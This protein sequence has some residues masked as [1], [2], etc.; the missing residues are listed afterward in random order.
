V[1]TELHPL[2]KCADDESWGDRCEGHLEGDVGVFGNDDL[3]A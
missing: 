3:D 2:G 1:G